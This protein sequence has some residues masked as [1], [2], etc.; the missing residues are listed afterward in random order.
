M[1]KF[2][3]P[4]I[5]DFEMKRE[6]RN[7]S[8]VSMRTSFLLTREM[9][10]DFYRNVVCDRNS[11]VRF[12]TVTL[13]RLHKIIGQASLMN[14]Q[15]ENRLAEMGVILAPSERNKGYGKE[16]VRMLLDK[17]FNELNLENIYGEC[18][19]CS[20][21]ITFWEKIADE[22]NAQKVMLP[23]RKFWLGEYWDSLYFNFERSSYEN[24]KKKI[25]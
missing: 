6:W 20:P 2:E 19:L 14:I 13:E 1:L 11:N 16:I 10:E 21:A 3:A 22:Y 12:W 25:R 15:W 9:Q 4:R 18:Y 23:N 7:E 5:E 17:G 24:Q 8:L